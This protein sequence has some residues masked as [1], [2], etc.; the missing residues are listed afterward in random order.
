M[1][2]C[3]VP[4]V[5][6]PK[7]IK[8]CGRPTTTCES[9]CKDDAFENA[10]INC[11]RNL[12]INDYNSCADTC[13]E[14]F[15]TCQTTCDSFFT[16]GGQSYKGYA[17]D[18][19]DIRYIDEE[20]DFEKGKLF[21]CRFKPDP[22]AVFGAS[23]FTTKSFR[24]K[25]R[26][27]YTVE[28]EAAVEIVELPKELKDTSVQ[29][30]TNLKMSYDKDKG[31]VSLEWTLSADDG[32]GAK[33]VTGYNIYRKEEGKDYG[34]LIETG[35]MLSKGTSRYEDTFTPNAG[36]KYFYKVGV[37]DKINNAAFVEGEFIYQ[38]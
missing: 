32:T 16:E 3:R 13:N 36:T 30:P 12:K 8:E 17:L 10:C 29:P 37:V 31:I 6:D 5:A 38:P 24:V 26:Y 23:P 33:D 25:V 9:E 20:T 27:N 34:S 28:K 14:N 18:T 1:D 19:K 2:A 22:N 7:C 4:G 15:D 35:K 11:K 21:R